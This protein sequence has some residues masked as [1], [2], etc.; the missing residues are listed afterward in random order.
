MIEEQT[1]VRP[2]KVAKF[3]KRKLAT[4]PWG[5]LRYIVKKS[6]SSDSTP[7]ANGKR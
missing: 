2:E 3:E 4:K 1:S 7:R 5:R 6:S